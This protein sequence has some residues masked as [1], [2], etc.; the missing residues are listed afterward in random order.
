MYREKINLIFNSL[1]SHRNTEQKVVMRGCGLHSLFWCRS[2][3]T[4]KLHNMFF[5]LV[6]KFQVVEIL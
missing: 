1:G 4:I 6:L 5:S 3:Y 2:N